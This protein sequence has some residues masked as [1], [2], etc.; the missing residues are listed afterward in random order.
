MG[1]NKCYLCLNF[2]LTLSS[3]TYTELICLTFKESYGLTC[4]CYA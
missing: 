4:L 3:K 1:T 2:F